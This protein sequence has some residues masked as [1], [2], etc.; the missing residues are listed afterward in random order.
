MNYKIAVIKGDGIGPEIVE[1]SMRV[2]D[3]IGEKYGHT[4]D[5]T[6]V[7]AGGAAIDACGTPLPQETVDIC[8]ASDA[9]LLGALGGP[10]WDNLPGDKR[11][12]AGL[13]GIRKA[14]GLFAN[15]RPAML[16]EELRDASPLKSEIIG[17]GLDVLVVRELT[18]DVYFGEKKKDGDFGASDLMNYTRPEVE[19]I[20]RV[21]FDSA[22]KRGGK[23]TSVDK[24]NV[25]ETSRFWRS[26]VLE[27]AKEYPDVE[28]D[29]LYVDNAAMQLVINPH[30]FDVI[31]TGNLFG[32]ILSDEASMLTGSIGMLP[33]ASLGEG[34]FGMYEPIH[35]SAPDIAGQDKANPI[36]TV[37]SVAMMLRY[38]LGLTAEADN[39]EGAVKKTL[40]QGYRTGDIAN[41]NS[42]VVGCVEMGEK[43][44][45]NL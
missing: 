12:E 23:V 41:E 40:A 1:A 19:R 39:I 31:L 30:Q 7:L 21:A 32:D 33:S 34:K 5:Y 6:E 10:K 27:I 43:I 4:F 11:P 24:A 38:S 2:L 3:K 13:L 14:L 36:A 18:G 20:A 45:S 29:H 35:G 28:L 9:V 8:K 42:D 17:D 25:L 37:L 22:R 44:I 15:L 26:V 16:F